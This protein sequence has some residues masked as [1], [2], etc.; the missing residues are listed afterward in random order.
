MAKRTPKIVVGEDVELAEVTEVK[1]LK[2][3]KEAVEEVAP[4]MPEVISPS[5]QN[6]LANINNDAITVVE[7][8]KTAPVTMVKVKL[9]RNHRCHIGGEWYS[10]QAGKQ[11]NVPEQVKLTLLKANLLMP[12]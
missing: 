8:N 7:S 4:V 11:Y 10:F 5:L 12:L 2:I 1:E 3:K 6:K 9:V